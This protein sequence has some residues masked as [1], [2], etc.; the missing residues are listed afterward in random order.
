MVLGGGERKPDLEELGGSL[1][2]L[3]GGDLDEGGD[4]GL[5]LRSR[6]GIACHGGE[7]RLDT[8]FFFRSPAGGLVSRVR[9]AWDLGGW[10]WEVR[11]REVEESVRVMKTTSRRQMDEFFV[12]I[13]NDTVDFAIIETKGKNLEKEIASSLAILKNVHRH[14]LLIK[15]KHYF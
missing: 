8:I 6:R 10:V 13:K 4:Q 3:A 5:L 14:S 15:L 9:W 11:K 7:S 12:T 2:G 1:E